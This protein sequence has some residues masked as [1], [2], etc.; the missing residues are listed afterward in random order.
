[1]GST[2]PERRR[3]PRRL[4]SLPVELRPPGQSYPT[5]CETTDVSLSGCYVKMLVPL[6][7]G[8][9]VDLRL[10]MGGEEVKAKGI[11][12]TADAALGNGIEFTEMASSCQVQL[13]HYLQTLPEVTLGSPDIIR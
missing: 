10:G 2:H 3:F 4:C 13:Q 6:P 9:A 11:V 5:S 8:T 12:K 1:M 7:V